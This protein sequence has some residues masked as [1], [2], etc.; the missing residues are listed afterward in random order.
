M[1]ENIVDGIRKALQDFLA[2]ELRELRGE[3]TALHDE[4]RQRVEAMNESLNERFGAMNEKFEGVNQRFDL[5]DEKQQARHRELLA[6]I[7]ESR[8]ASELS[9]MREVASPR[10]RVALLEAARR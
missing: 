3:L 4:T 2:P 9:T 5:M 10:E 1:A 6:A 7:A 8:A